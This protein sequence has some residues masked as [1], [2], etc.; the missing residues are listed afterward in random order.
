MRRRS[1]SRTTATGERRAC[2]ASRGPAPPNRAPRRG[3]ACPRSVLDPAPLP[4]ALHTA[5]ELV[6]AGIAIHSDPVVG[7]RVVCQEHRPSQVQLHLPVPA[8][9]VDFGLEANGA[10]LVT[11]MVGLPHAPS[12]DRASA[13]HLDALRGDT[14]TEKTVSTTPV[15]AASG[16]PA[17]ATM[18]F[19]IL[20]YVPQRQ[21]LVT[22]ASI[23]ASVGFGI[24]ASNAA[25]AIR[26][27]GWQ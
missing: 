6:V 18:A 4:P 19:L 11:A 3:R 27:P 7:G 17:A 2:A 15:R 26:N 12:L 20:A 14:A 25:A 16:H 23:S 22:E 24:C 13:Q 10:A 21:R 5:D 9:R 1:P 8:D